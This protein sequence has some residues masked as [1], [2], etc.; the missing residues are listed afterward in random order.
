MDKN[1]MVCAWS[2]AQSRAVIDH[3]NTVSLIDKYV[4]DKLFHMLKFISSPDLI[5]FSYDDRSLCQLV[6]RNFS[7][8]QSQQ[9][10]FWNGFSKYVGLNLNKKR[11]EVSN[12]MKKLLKVKTLCTI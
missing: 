5:L 10:L 3:E 12:A 8:D 4:K 2:Q 9:I 1:K 7:V 6:C 11:T